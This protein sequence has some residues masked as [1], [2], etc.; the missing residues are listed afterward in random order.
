MSKVNVVKIFFCFPNSIIKTKGVFVD[1]LIRDVQLDKKIGYA[2]YLKKV[3]LHK[4]L[5]DYFNSKNINTYRPLLADNKNKIEKI[6]K[7]ATQK[8]LKQLSP[9]SLSVFIFPWLGEKYDTTFGGVNGFAPYAST[10]HLFISLTKFSSQSLKETLTH[11]FNHAVFFYYHKSSL[12]LNLLE[13]FV[14]EGLAENFR[15]EVMGGKPS[16]WSTALNKKQC[17]LTLLSLKQS[18][19]SRKYSLYRN[20]FFGGKKYK[21]WTGYSIGY[22]I[23]KSFREAYPE[24]SWKEVMKMKPETIFVMSPFTKKEV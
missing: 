14:F 24:K 16:P 5:L 1:A 7:L 3:Y 13:T 11:E 19:H 6:I 2:G 22:N 9:F 18:L 17:I 15:E 21:R 20:V 12:E 23:I 4:H 10:I 8:Y